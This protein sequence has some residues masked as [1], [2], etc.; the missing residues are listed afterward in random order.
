MEMDFDYK[1]SSSDCS[2]ALKAIF[3]GSLTGMIESSITYPAEFVKTQMHLKRSRIRRRTIQCSRM[4]VQNRST[5][6]TSPLD[7]VKHTIRQRGI[8][9]LYS[10]FSVVLYGSIPK[11]AARFGTYELMIKKFESKGPIT[12]SI[13]FMCGLVAGLTEAFL[14]VTPN[15]TIK[16]KFIADRMSANPKYHG[17]IHGLRLILNE[18]GIRG[19]YAGLMPTLLKQGT[20]QAIRFQ[21]MGMLKDWYCGSEPNKKVNMLLIGMMGAIAGA[22]SVFANNPIDVVK[23]RMQ[24]MDR[25]RYNGTIDCFRKIIRKEGMKALYKGTVPRLYHVCT[26]V[27][28]TFMIYD[29]IMRYMDKF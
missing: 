29:L 12:P 10:G 7:V 9:G 26:D 18:Q 8:L 21:V 5:Y 24:G 14:V 3:A 27:S 23:T 4:M 13:T 2:Y 17:F 11:T 19:T 1:S 15:E 16:I 22:V 25:K 20:N 28:I 6:H